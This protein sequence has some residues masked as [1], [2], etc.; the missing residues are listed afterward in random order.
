MS[1]IKSIMHQLGLSG[2]PE[3]NFTLSVPAAPD[4]TMKLA[5][6]NAGTI[7]QDIMTVDAAGRVA[8][9]AQGQSIAAN[10]YV[11][12]PGG[13]II[14]WGSANFT[15]ADVSVTFPIPFTIFNVITATCAGVIGSVSLTSGGTTTVLLRGENSSGG[16]LNSGGFGWIAIG[17]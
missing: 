5:R 1:L 4:G 9:P 15:G 11:R 13:P 3:K 2:D 14:Q 16:I 17:Y 6:G 10:G 12:L 7:A 8:F